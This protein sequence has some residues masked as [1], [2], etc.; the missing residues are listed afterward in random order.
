MICYQMVFIPIVVCQCFDWPDIPV[1]SRS[2]AAIQVTQCYWLLGAVAWRPATGREARWELMRPTN[3]PG[4]FVVP[5]VLG[6]CDCS[7]WHKP[8]A[9]VRFVR[10]SSCNSRIR[11]EQAGPTAGKS[12]S[13]KAY[14]VDLWQ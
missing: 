4:G 12:G 11:C 5:A 6:P 2:L 3:P 10:F 8:F 9:K 14:Q 7:P 13:V 1:H